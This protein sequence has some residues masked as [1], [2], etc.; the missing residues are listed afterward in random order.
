MI[1]QSLSKSPIL[2]KRWRVT[3]TDGTHFDFSSDKSETYIDHKDKKLRD[4]YRARH[5]SN[6]SEYELI[7]NIIPSP[8]LFSYYIS[9]GDSTS[10]ID[11]IKSLNK[12]LKSK[13]GP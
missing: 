11:N 7:N 9:W 13:Y 6:K 2:F 12:L 4:A 3:M 1:I 8:A 10:I 5:L